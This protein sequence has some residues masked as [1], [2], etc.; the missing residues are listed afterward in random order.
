MAGIS[1]DIEHLRVNRDDFMRAFDEVHPAFGVSE[2]ELQ[3]VVQNGIIRF[4]KHIDVRAIT[5]APFYISSPSESYRVCC[6][7]AR[8]SWNK[9]ALQSEHRWFQSFSMDLLEQERPPWPPPS[10]KHQSFLLSSWCLPIAW[11]ASRN[12]SRLRP[13]TKC[14]RTA[15]RALSVLSSSIISSDYSVSFGESCSPYLDS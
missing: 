11:W 13:S 8:F 12:N 9:C 7:T 1:D 10:P 3:Q 5:G 2:E 14:L 15:T 4:D 6:V